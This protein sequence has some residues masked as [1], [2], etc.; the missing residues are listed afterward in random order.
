MKILVSDERL[1]SY[2]PYNDFLNENK[3]IGYLKIRA[4]TASEAVPIVNLNITVTKEIGEYDVI[5][6]EGVI[7][8]SGMINDIALPACDRSISNLEV[9]SCAVYNVS[10]KKDKFNENFYNVKVYNGIKTL[11]TINGGS[12]D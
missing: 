7:D 1:K 3:G 4:F 6:F 11:T 8:S 5:F 9:P 10:A 2:K 12:Y